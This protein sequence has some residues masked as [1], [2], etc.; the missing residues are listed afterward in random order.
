MPRRRAPT[1]RPAAAPVATL[2]FVAGTRSAA[3]AR[4]F[5]RD[6]LERW[7]CHA[8]VADTEL[9]VSELVTNAVLHAGTAGRLRLRLVEGRV[10]VEVLD[11]GGGEP[12]EQPVDL[13][14]PGGRG[15]LIVGEVAAGWGVEHVDGDGKVVWAE[16]GT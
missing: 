12:R 1:R 13:L 11:E 6:V 7:G 9:V 2:D 4:H 5:V 3:E 8:L 15:L 16:I 14:R 10:R